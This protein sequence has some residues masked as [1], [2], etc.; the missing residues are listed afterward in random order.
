M[1]DTLGFSLRSPWMSQLTGTATRDTRQSATSLIFA[2]NCAYIPW[3]SPG[4]EMLSQRASRRISTSEM[5]VLSTSKCLSL[6]DGLIKHSISFHLLSVSST[7]LLA[8][9][10]RKRKGEEKKQLKR[11]ASRSSSHARES[12]GPRRPVTLTRRPRAGE[13]RLVPAFPH[14]GGGRVGP[15]HPL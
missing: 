13:H 12:G 2:N 15:P 8:P 3:E 11:Q 5:T 4:G 9:K 1:G 10:L 14:L 7:R 6:S